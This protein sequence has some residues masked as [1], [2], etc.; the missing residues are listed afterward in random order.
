MSIT[1]Q[2]TTA[3]LH[4]LKLY[5]NSWKPQGIHE[6]GCKAQ[7]WHTRPTDLAALII[8]II[9]AQRSITF[10]CIP[11]IQYKMLKR[12]TRDEKM[13]EKGHTTLRMVHLT[14]TDNPFSLT[15][16]TILARNASG[17]LHREHA[18]LP[19]KFEALFLQIVQGS[20]GIHIKKRG[21]RSI[22]RI[23]STLHKKMIL[24]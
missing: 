18:R 12:T 7:L 3:L 1:R 10:W 2:R 22:N 8:H 15:G 19:E 11:R 24:K 13:G 20:S 4:T 17:S 9:Q 5:H 23:K 14:S 21:S 6:T 16:N